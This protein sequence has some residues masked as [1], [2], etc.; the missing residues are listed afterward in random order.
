MLYLAIGKYIDLQ[1]SMIEA[2]DAGLV[3][4]QGGWPL[5]G[6]KAVYLTLFLWRLAHHVA[7]QADS[8]LP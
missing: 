6:D 3:P 7:A 4:V 1:I 5:H 8:H 2:P